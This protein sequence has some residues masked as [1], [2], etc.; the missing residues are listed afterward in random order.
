MPL[1]LELSAVHRYN[2]FQGSIRTIATRSAGLQQCTWRAAAIAR[3][4]SAGNRA[5][6]SSLV[7]Q[8]AAPAP[9]DRARQTCRRLPRRRPSPRWCSAR[10]LRAQTGARWP[11]RP[12]RR[13]TGSPTGRT[14]TP[15]ARLD[16]DL[17]W[18]GRTFRPNR[19]TTESAEH[20]K[21]LHIQ[22]T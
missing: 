13:P 15:S 2:A 4:M 3:C 21:T 12:N 14:G 8:S 5:P 19:K 10:V 7:Y 1:P 20:A 22:S 9:S 6:A 11:G 18:M 16:E 17:R